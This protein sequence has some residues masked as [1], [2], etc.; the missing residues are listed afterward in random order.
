VANYKPFNL[1]S[2]HKMRGVEDEF[3]RLMSQATQ[4]CLQRPTN[5]KPRELTIK[6]KLTPDPSDA[7][8]VIVEPA[9]PQL[10][11]TQAPLDKYRMTTGA[12]GDLR[13]QPNFPLDPHQ[14]D[15]FGEGD[16]E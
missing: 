13:F 6:L 16:E 11:L 2:I 12:K 15:L 9:F 8:N 3:D 14:Q 7:D 5:T 10:K 4:D 1:R